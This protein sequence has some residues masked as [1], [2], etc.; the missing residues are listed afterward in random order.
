MST[1]AANAVRHRIAGRYYLAERIGSGGMG[2]VYRARDETVGRDVAVKIFRAEASSPE[3]IARQER[4]IRMLSSF[5]HPGIV[6]LFDAG[7]HNFNGEVRRYVV[8]ELM[9][10]PTLEARLD[11]G[12]MPSAAIAAIGAQLAEALEYLHERGIVHRDVK[13]ANILISDV[14]SSG[15][16]R[17]A[18][19][20]DFGVAHFIDGS[21]LTSDGVVIGTASFV[22]PEQ[23]AGEPISGASDVYSLGLV[24]LEA[25]T[26]VREYTGTVVEAAITRLSRNPA[27]PDSLPHEWQVLLMA[28]TDRDPAVRPSA[29]DVAATLRGRPTDELPTVDHHAAH[30]SRRVDDPARRQRLRT[31]VIVA[32]GTVIIGSI[33]AMAW[34]LGALWAG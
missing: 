31:A 10:D 30:R 6:S 34:M 5:S 33:A 15:F 9:P 25:L 20:S 7:L 23:V 4:E 14:S 21:R 22:S 2:S 13:P 1:V 3:D 19:L 8:M 28:M 24:L 16:E 17:T 29:G 26:G 32:S 11:V 27:V 18:K 12:P